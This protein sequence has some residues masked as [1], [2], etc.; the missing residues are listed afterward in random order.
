MKQLA[1]FFFLLQ[2][3]KNT[4][5]SE[6]SYIS[7]LFNK[8]SQMYL[9]CYYTAISSCSQVEITAQFF[10]LIKIIRKSYDLHMM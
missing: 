4:Q 6:V 8:A 10:Q 2:S 9:G 5:I 1:P 3:I 7:K